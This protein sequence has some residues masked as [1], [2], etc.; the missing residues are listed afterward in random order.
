VGARFTAAARTTGEQ[1]V[2]CR[3]LS[4]GPVLLA[5]AQAEAA[6]ANGGAAARVIRSAAEQAAEHA[7]IEN[8]RGAFGPVIGTAGI[9][10]AVI[11]FGS[12]GSS[13]ATLD[14]V[15]SATDTL[16]SAWVER[17]NEWAPHQW[18]EPMLIGA[19][20]IGAILECLG[21]T[22][23]AAEAESPGRMPSQAG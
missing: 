19:A 2:A 16:A 14:Q 4:H 13:I 7:R 12:S 9:A 3:I 11:T 15:R 18:L 21:A 17:T 10:R 6:N 1:H 8:L 23:I 20:V 5:A 22:A